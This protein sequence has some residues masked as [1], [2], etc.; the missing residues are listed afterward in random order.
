MAQT[1]PS[2]SFGSLNAITTPSPTQSPQV[3]EKIG[4]TSGLAAPKYI[5]VDISEQRMY[6]FLD[7]KMHK[8]YTISSGLEYPTPRGIFFIKNKYPNAYS[9]IYHVWM[10]YWME[11]YYHPLLGATFGIHELP[12]WFEGGR[13]VRR[14]REKLGSPSTGGCISLDFGKAKEVYNFSEVGMPVYIYE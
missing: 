4:N 9:G 14:P 5:E 12:Y 1:G 3:S 11:F 2:Q 8:T 6:L 13:K 7:G 10:P